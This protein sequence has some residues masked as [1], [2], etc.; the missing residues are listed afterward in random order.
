MHL[1][2]QPNASRQLQLLREFKHLAVIGNI[3]LQLHAK[4]NLIVFATF[5]LCLGVP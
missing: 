3:H 5:R 1:T 2:D 4:K